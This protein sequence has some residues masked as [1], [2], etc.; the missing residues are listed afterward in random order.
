M[1]KGYKMISFRLNTKSDYDIINTLEE[2]P[3]ATEYVRRLI[4]K[5]NI[6]NASGYKALSYRAKNEKAKLKFAEWICDE[7]LEALLLIEYYGFDN[8]M[9]NFIKNGGHVDLKL[10][11][12]SKFMQDIENE[13]KELIIL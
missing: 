12:N 5:D 7:D 13:N 8:V 6:N 11:N 2:K 10:E 1:D 4:R 3:N 9:E